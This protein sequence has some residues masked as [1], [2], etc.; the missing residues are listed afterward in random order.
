[1][2]PIPRRPVRHPLHRLA[3]GV[4]LLAALTG[5]C[6]LPSD[7]SNEVVVSSDRDS[8]L[9][10]L[11]DSLQ[12]AVAITRGG[13][14]VP[15]A[16]AVFG[17][18][19]SG[20]VL[21]TP[22]GLV[23]AVGVGFAEISVAA[24][25]FAEAT[26]TVMPVQVKRA[27]RITAVQTERGV[28]NEATWGELLTIVGTGLDPADAVV[29]VGTAA[30]RVAGFVAG[31][32]AD[33]QGW[34]TLRVW[35]PALVPEQSNLV[36]ARLS[37]T[38]AGA[39][40]PLRILQRDIF[41]P[42]EASPR[43]LDV[44]APL[45]RPDLVLEVR[46]AASSPPDCASVWVAGQ[47][48]CWFDAYS[49]L[50]PNTPATDSVT[51]VLKFQRVLDNT[52]VSIEV[53]EESAS[54]QHW[55]ISR[56]FSLCSDD[57]GFIFYPTTHEFTALR[58]SF[59]LAL[60]DLGGRRISF[61]ATLF[62]I[63]WSP[64]VPWPG[65]PTGSIPYE[66]RVYPGYLSEKPPDVAEE[67]D[68]C[69]LAYGL[70][71]NDTLALTFDNG[72]DLDWFRFTVPAVAAAPQADVAE[73]E[74]NNTVD[75]AD[76]VQYG[77]RATGTI[78]PAGDVDYF[79]FY[80]DSGATLDIEVVASRN[81][82]AL[83]SI[84]FLM[85]EDGLVAWNDEF[86]A[87]EFDSRVTVAAPKSGWYW[88]YVTDYLVRGG[89]DFF[90]TVSVSSQAGTVPFLTAEVCCGSGGG[91]FDP[92][93]QLWSDLLLTEGG[94]SPLEER[95]GLLEVPVPPG[96]YFLLVYNRAGD[97]MDYQLRT[98]LTTAGAASV[99]KAARGHPAR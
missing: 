79:T 51:I 38:G 47:G 65:R 56:N 3:T 63:D 20:V 29:F 84:L 97:A 75:A 14:A 4:V 32:P 25:G 37:G 33:P 66:L 40:W 15:G 86:L 82:S 96:D 26:S 54:P 99:G 52:P 71:G 78:S 53:R 70:T 34:D 57:R 83:N 55:V 36:V 69:H 50:R 27:I 80:A 88:F 62:G 90:Y 7:A 18:T 42:N 59:V 6:L 49:F 31:N 61:S 44:S 81:G 11:G 1:M 93:I 35:T 19:D 17:T 77:D 58:D 92:R 95:P 74:P 12:L 68:Q 24:L 21:V 39:Q 9:L 89:A 2:I 41:E 85:N 64:E 46:S 10:S 67:N 94:I 23:R 28:D 73:T 72:T 13:T 5:A 87:S 60:A 45:L 76:T 43:Q 98:R 30:A 22:Q 91:Q 16:Q 48:E 8:L